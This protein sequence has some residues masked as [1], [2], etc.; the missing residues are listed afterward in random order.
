MKARIS[1]IVKLMSV[2]LSV[3]LFAA[4][5]RPALA[6]EVVAQAPDEPFVSMGGPSSSDIATAW[7]AP[8]FEVAMNRATPRGDGVAVV[9]DT[10]PGIP[11]SLSAG[12]GQATQLGVDLSAASAQAEREGWPWYGKAA[13]VVGCAL[14]AGLAT[15]AI[16]EASHKGSH[17]QDSSTHYTL[18]ADD[19]ATMNVR[20]GAD[21]TTHT[22]TTTTGW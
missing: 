3:A 21:N 17:D 22:S 14:V 15:W 5:C 1:P 9:S 19:G 20:I 16:V 6:A 11:L 7:S 12:T 18:T 4:G 10:S 2:L 8:A 13:V